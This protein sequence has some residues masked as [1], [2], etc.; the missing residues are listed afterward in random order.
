MQQ[1][2]AALPKGTYRNGDADRRIRQACRS[3]RESDDQERSRSLIDFAGTSLA[4]NRGINLVL[5]YTR[6]YA[7]YGVRAIIAPD[8]PEQRVARFSRSNDGARGLDPQCGTARAGLCASYHRAISS[9]VVL[10]C[11]A[12]IMPALVPAEGASC[13]WGLQLRGSAEHRPFNILFFNAGGTGARPSAGR[14]LRD[15]FSERHS[16]N[17]RSRS[18]RR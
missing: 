6:A 4:S 1:A 3:E 10:G 18:A 2:I 15:E 17:S 9:E 16:L 8:I 13:N 12:D 7:S 5:N 11:L 14:L